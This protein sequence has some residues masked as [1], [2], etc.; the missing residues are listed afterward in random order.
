[1]RNLEIAFIFKQIADLLE[2]Q[3]ANPFRIRAYRRAA[4]NIEGLADNIETLALGGTLRNIAGVGEDL[5]L[6]IDEYIRTEKIDFH[7][8]LKR[9]IPLG[10]V[11]I[12]EIPSVGPKTAKEIYDQFRV[13]TI[14]EL[15]AL[16]KTDKLLSVKGFKKK[17]IDNIL[18]GIELYRARRGTYLLGRAVP[19]AEQLCKYLEASAERVA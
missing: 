15:E 9:E 7:E 10:L 1:M 17:T 14:E 8:Q 6:K 16:C 19:I 2:I 5:A 13:Q 11:R 4:L 12:V 3:G 18:R